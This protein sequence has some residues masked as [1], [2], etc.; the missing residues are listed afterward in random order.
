LGQ[1]ALRPNLNSRQIVDLLPGEV[2]TEINI[3]DIE[4]ALADYLYSGYLDSQNR[5]TFRLHQHDAMAIPT[6]LSFK[7]IGSLSH[8]IVE[9]LERVRPLNFGQARQIPG[10][11]PAALS[12]LLVHLTA[13]QQRN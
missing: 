5:A 7:T 10:L 1:L 12:T 11:T 3:R 13:L 6:N 9:R 2:K 8:E 4:T